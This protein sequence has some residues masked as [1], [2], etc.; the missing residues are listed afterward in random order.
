MPSDAAV[1]L[2]GRSAVSVR[3]RGRSSKPHAL[4]RILLIVA[5]EIMFCM[6]VRGCGSD[7]SGLCSG[8]GIRERETMPHTDK[9]DL[10]FPFD[11]SLDCVRCYLLLSGARGAVYFKNESAL[12]TAAQEPVQWGTARGVLLSGPHHGCG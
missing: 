9:K 3:E 5:G 8:R 7:I 12:Q 10:L 1:G 11:I 2:P 6:S 4:I